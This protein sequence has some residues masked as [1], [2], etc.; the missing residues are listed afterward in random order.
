MKKIG[1][2]ILAFLACATVILLYAHAGAYFFGW[3]NGGGIFPMTVLLIVLAAV[4][5]AITGIG[6]REKKGAQKL[7]DKNTQV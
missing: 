3:R 5:Y 7:S 6:E 4:W 1:L 2:Y